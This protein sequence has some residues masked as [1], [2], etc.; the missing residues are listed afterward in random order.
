MITNNEGLIYRLGSAKEFGV[1]VTG[2]GVEFT[3][4][5]TQNEPTYLN[6]YNVNNK[7][8]ATVN[9]ND[10]KYNSKIGSVLVSGYDDDFL[11]EYVKA[12]EVYLDSFTKAST[13]KRKYKEDSTVTDRGRVYRSTFDWEGDARPAY[14]FNEIIA[15]QLHVR[16]FTKHASSKVKNKGTF[17]GVTEK[18][19]YLKELGINQVVLMPSY[20]FDEI[21]KPDVI[22][23]PTSIES[24][25]LEGSNEKYFINY[26]G[27]KAGKYFMPKANYAMQDAYYEF[28]QMVK[29]MHKAGIE[30]VMRFY[31]P[32]SVRRVLIPEIL[33]FWATEYHVDGF[34]VMG[35]N[36]PVK[37]I[38][39]D[40]YLADVKLY[41]ADL[42]EGIFNENEYHNSNIAIANNGFM[43]ATRK[44][45]KSDE[46]LLNDFLYFQRN[47]PDDI[48]AI[49]Y[50]TDYSGFTM[51]DLVSFDYKHNEN[52]KE[53]NK[54][55]ENFNNSWNCGV[56]GYTKRKAI[57]EL[58]LKQ[59]K[60]AFTFVI[61]AQGVP[62]LLSGD[63][64][65]NGQNGNN[66]SYCQDNEIGWVNWKSTK[67]AIVIFNFV[68]ELIKLR[69]NHPIL[70]PNM[71]FKI[72]DYASCGFPD[73]SYHSDE[74]WAPKFDSYLRY[75]G[76]MICGKYVKVDECHDDD[77][78]YIAYNMHWEN[79][80]L[81]LPKL[82]KGL[83]WEV[84]MDTSKSEILVNDELG[85]HSGLINVPGRSIIVLKSAVGS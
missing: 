46:N 11:Y 5:I 24:R 8:L 28:K 49:N 50:I 19:D 77:F 55:G 43:N 56:E 62:M 84:I 76:V 21:D 81:A 68:K 75:I 18:I 38:A 20:E 78:F 39:Q 36:I 15:Y 67:D 1:N 44:Y 54:D 16:G 52:N 73:L 17:L 79:H 58:R 7:K 12:S 3:C 42:D 66:N 35:S 85:E 65:L 27:F 41:F 9:M 37:V 34:F 14:D 64:L 69:K 59:I 74:A 61:L 80:N 10:Y 51:Y 70:H 47:N 6:L 63:E 57:N 53:D 25:S 22:G 13:G 45:L 31:F 71:Q 33:R 4:E 60:N 30:V 26:W 23:S 29:L 2:D 32:D 40:L 48:H 72:M 83:K 82:P